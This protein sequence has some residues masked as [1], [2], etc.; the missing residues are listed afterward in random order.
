MFY[1][2]NRFAPLKRNNTNLKT[3]SSQN[4]SYIN[5]HTHTPHCYLYT[6]ST[7]QY[8]HPTIFVFRKV[9]QLSFIIPLPLSV[10]F[11]KIST[12]G[13]KKST[14]VLKKI[15]NDLLFNF[16]F[17]TLYYFLKKLFWIV[18]VPRH[19]Q[20][21]YL[22]RMILKTAFNLS[23]NWTGV[24]ITLRGKLAA[25]GNKRSTTFKCLFG[26]GSAANILSLAQTDFRTIS[27]TTGVLGVTSII[28]YKR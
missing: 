5:T 11:S 21:L 19:K 8:T 14:I 24:S 4:K 12:I 10:R 17:N 28:S 9:G 16:S 26:D 15:L 7:N 20:I 2:T 6:P 1:T 13:V 3:L 22:I 23:N 18:P 27:T 25:T